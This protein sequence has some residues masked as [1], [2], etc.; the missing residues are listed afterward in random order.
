[1]SIQLKGKGF[2]FDAGYGEIAAVDN[3]V[4]GPAV[5]FIHGN[6]A[7]KEVFHHQFT[8]SLAR[9]YRLIAFDLPGH[10]ASDDAAV[11]GDVYRMAPMTRMVR[12]LLE[13]LDACDAV[14]VGWSL[15]GHLAIELAGTYR[16]HRGLVISG[17]PP[18]GPGRGEIA[19]AFNQTEEMALTDKDD[20]SEAD[21]AL[22]AK[23]ILGPAAAREKIFT[24]AV[25]RTDGTMR[26]TSIGDW[27]MNEEAGH[28]QKGVIAKWHHPIA[29]IQG[30]TEP[31]VNQAWMK[32]I[33]WANLW[34][35]KYHMVKGAGHASFL[36][37]P[38]AYNALLDRYLSDGIATR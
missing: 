5:L 20:F 28:Y 36:E 10:G 32:D 31:F 35:G 18:F 15:G 34:Q 8:S 14:L 1:M 16:E 27:A 37:K 2:R 9:K 6:S 7:C 25:R 4:D 30:E 29:V 19:L 11:P 26:T 38:E 3:E 17:T 13:S 23:A 21:A 12:A 24:D 22:Y 33:S